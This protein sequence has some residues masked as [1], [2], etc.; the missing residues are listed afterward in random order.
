MVGELIETSN[1]MDI[2]PFFELTSGKIV[3]ETKRGTM[4]EQNK[5]HP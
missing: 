1:F 4:E 5:C 2:K 3:S